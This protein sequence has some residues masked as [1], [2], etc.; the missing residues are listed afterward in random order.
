[1]FLVLYFIGGT[2]T[3]FEM[4]GK[5]YRIVMSTLITSH[6]LIVAGTMDVQICC[7]DTASGA[8][9]HTLSGHQ[10]MSTL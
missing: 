5:V 10:G 4:P 2:G 6:M 7:C 3:E 8:F 1:M 9:T